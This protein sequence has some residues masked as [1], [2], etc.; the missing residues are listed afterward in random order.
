[1]AAAK[2]PEKAVCAICGVR[3]KAGPEP[4]AASFVHEGKTYSFCQQKCKE[5]FCLDPE[6]WI[7]AAADAAK[8]PG[9]RADGKR[10]QHGTKARAAGA[11]GG[12]AAAPS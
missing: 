4:V 1:M 11:P 7:Q 9:T 6:R 8:E 2:P 3:E 10:H 5:E 12:G